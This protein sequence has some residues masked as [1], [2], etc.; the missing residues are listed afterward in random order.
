VSRRQVRLRIITGIVAAAAVAGAVV[1]VACERGT[2]RSVE[3]FCT[4]IE[5]AKDLDQALATLDAE[6][7]SPSVEALR[8][9]S[10]VAPVEIEPDVDA[11][12][13]LTEVLATTI[14][15][16]RT[17]KPEALEQA[18]REHAG[19]LAS[20]EAA[21]Q[22]VQDYTNA[23]CGIRLNTTE[24]PETSTTVAGDVPLDGAPASVPPP[25]APA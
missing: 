3:A 24:V 1:V 8:R 9:A 13:A 25:T 17:D 15:T 11:V 5:Q 20:V 4:E 10:R 12:L 23:N 22:R 2:E 14:A 6:Q 19:E 18:L 21:G 7:L 16:A